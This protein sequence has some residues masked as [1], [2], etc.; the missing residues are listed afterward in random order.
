[1]ERMWSTN[2]L[3][4]AQSKGVKGQ[5]SGEKIQDMF[6]VSFLRYAKDSFGARGKP[7]SDSVSC[8]GRK[9]GGLLSPTIPLS[10]RR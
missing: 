6:Q 10:P 1:M 3:S 2:G 7:E 8:S 4:L 5:L 9:A